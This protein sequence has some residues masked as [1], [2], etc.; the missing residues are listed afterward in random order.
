MAEVDAE[1]L[2]CS[3]D[4]AVGTVVDG[5]EGGGVVEVADGAV[6]GGEHFAAGGVRAG[7]CGR[8]E[9][10]AGHAVDLA[11]VVAVEIEGGGGVDHL[12]FL[13]AAQAAPGGGEV[14]RWREVERGGERGRE[15]ERGGWKEEK[16]K[17]KR[18]VPRVVRT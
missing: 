13:L 9:S 7:G 1:A 17:A 15:G 8:L 6:V 10:A 5:L 2:A 3:A 4:V 11:D 12:G 18:V 16:R 14:E